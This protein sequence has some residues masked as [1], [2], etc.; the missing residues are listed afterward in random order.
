MA[1]CRASM[2]ACLSLMVVMVGLMKGA[3]AAEYVVGDS[4]GWTLPPNTS[5]YSDWAASK[6]FQLGD[7]VSFNWTGNHTMAEATKEEYDNCS[8][9][10][11]WSTTPVNVN[12]ISAGSRYFIC[13]VGD[14]C[15][16]GQKVT[17]TVGSSSP[18]SAPPPPSGAHTTVASL[19]L[20][21]ISS[22]LVISFFTCM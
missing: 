2:I 12:L 16:Q 9:P 11:I 22:T 3:T 15:E 10:G 6:T 5:F 20:G 19:L 7:V 1:S 13:T 21:L 4:L 8:D 17:I 18:T 14:H